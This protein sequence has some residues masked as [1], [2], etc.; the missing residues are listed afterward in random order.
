MSRTYWIDLLTVETGQEFLDN[1]GDVSG[2]SDRRWAV[3][4]KSGQAITCCAT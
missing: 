4:Q 3:V 1:G 2:F